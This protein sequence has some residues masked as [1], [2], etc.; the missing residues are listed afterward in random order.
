MEDFKNF[1]SW[2]LFFFFQTAEERTHWKRKWVQIDYGWPKIWDMSPTNTG[3]EISQT[4][5]ECSAEKIL[6]IASPDR[7]RRMVVHRKV[8]SGGKH[9][10]THTERNTY[11][12]LY[13]CIKCLAGLHCDS[14]LEA[15]GG[16]R[17][18]VCLTA[19]KRRTP[20]R[21]SGRRVARVS[22]RFPVSSPSSAEIPRDWASSVK[23]PRDW[24]S[25]GRAGPWTCGSEARFPCSQSPWRSAHPRPASACPPHPGARIPSPHAP[26][27]TK[28]T[29]WSPNAPGL[30]SW[31]IPHI[32][33][34][35]QAA[36][37][38]GGNFL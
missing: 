10:H 33:Y 19:G 20:C 1:T 16:I 27:A 7:S 4:W 28:H 14:G 24:A 15:W 38:P 17:R 8:I 23:I 34:W 32:T 35:D 6:G 5:R 2:A 29:L 11:I 25:S 22:H 21:Q 12:K 13:R 36:P 9:T 3:S 31:K 30:P 37:Q 18:S 26:E